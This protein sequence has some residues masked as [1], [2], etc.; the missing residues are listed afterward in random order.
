MTPTDDSNVS[1][2]PPSPEP[3]ATIMHEIFPKDEDN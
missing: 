3:L 2:R 1:I